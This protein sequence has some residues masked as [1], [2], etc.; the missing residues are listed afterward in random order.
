MKLRDLIFEMTGKY[1]S[2]ELLVDNQSAVGKLNRPA[3]GNMWLD[4]KWRVV[5][6]RLI[7]KLVGIHC[8]PT[9]EQVADIVTKSL[10]PLVHEKAVEI[11]GMYCFKQ[12]DIECTSADARARL[13][14]TDVKVP[15][16]KHTCIH[17]GAKDC[18]VCKEF[19]NAFK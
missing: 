12:K 19:Y 18:S 2:T 5:N 6:Q 16:I 15:L 11:L 9:A 3:G 13:Q 10:S 8:I 14:R 4:L 7:D 1:V 17:E